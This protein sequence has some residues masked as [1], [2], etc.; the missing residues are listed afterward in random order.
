MPQCSGLSCNLGQKQN[1]WENQVKVKNAIVSVCLEQMK[2]PS[3]FTEPDRRNKVTDN[4]N[5]KTQ[6][7]AR[8]MSMKVAL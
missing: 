7:Y 1:M 5:V 2:K 6:I 3:S 4:S 8:H